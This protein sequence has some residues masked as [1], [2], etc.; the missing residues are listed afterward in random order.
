MPAGKQSGEAAGTM[1]AGYSLHPHC[2][3][4][5]PSIQPPPPA[6]HSPIVHSILGFINGLSH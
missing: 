3:L 2:W 5:T 4:P 1:R 6:V